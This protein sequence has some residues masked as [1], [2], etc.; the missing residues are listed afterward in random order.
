MRITRPR[1]MVFMAVVVVLVLVTTVTN[2][3]VI[4][5]DMNFSE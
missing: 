2:M 3:S 5:M 1:Q 4:T